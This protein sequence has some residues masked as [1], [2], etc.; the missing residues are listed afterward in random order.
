MD[1]ED[2]GGVGIGA[3]DG[4]ALEDDV[5][6]EGDQ[7]AL[8]E[9]DADEQLDVDETTY[10]THID[11]ND[12]VITG[13]AAHTTSMDASAPPATAAAA[14]AENRVTTPFL[15]KF[16]RARILGTRA[17]QVSMNAPLLIQLEGESDPLEIA[18]KELKQRKVPFTVRRYLPDGSYEDWAVRELIQDDV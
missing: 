12:T 10:N 6:L 11:A 8:Q 3:A 1:E 5:A 7:A 9:E 16:E 17:L 14:A 15:T 4:D 13:S 2:E 18:E